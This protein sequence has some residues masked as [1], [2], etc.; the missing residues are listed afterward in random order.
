[1]KLESKQPRGRPRAFDRARALDQALTLFWQNGYEGTSVADLTAALGITPPS[2]YAA[3]GSK[4]ALYREALDL[5]LATRSERVRAALE[6]AGPARAALEAA[7]N[8]AADIFAGADGPR[9]C[10]V[11][12]GVLRCAPEHHALAAHTA[13]LRRL[14]SDTIARRLERARVDGE[15]A[16]GTDS[17]ALAGFY[18]SLIQ[19]MS[20]QAIDGASRAALGDIVGFAMAAWPAP[21]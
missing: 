16:A 2:L 7:L 12:G 17:A 10:P 18:A 3:F 20:V 6:R 8:L 1:M 21:R 4:D 14:M 5:Y 13:A 11:A 15:L 9:G 19:G